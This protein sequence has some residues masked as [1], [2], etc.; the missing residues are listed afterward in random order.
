MIVVANH[1]HVE[2]LKKLLLEKDLKLNM[3]KVIC[4]EVEKA[5]KTYHMP[6]ANRHPAKQAHLKLKQESQHQESHRTNQVVEADTVEATEHHIEAE[7]A[8]I[9]KI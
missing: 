4:N 7:E 1:N 3:A 6:G 8:F 5:A 2:L 9:S